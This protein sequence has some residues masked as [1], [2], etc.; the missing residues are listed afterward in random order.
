MY[1]AAVGVLG[2]IGITLIYF[3]IVN[4]QKVVRNVFRFNLPKPFSCSF[5][6][7]FW[8]SMA[9]MICHVDLVE[10]VYTS[11]IAPFIYLYVEDYVTN[12]WQ[13]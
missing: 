4:V 11:S 13:L 9:Y 1:Q 8:F 10:A 7:S 12:K 2:S 5:C 3:Y 6:M